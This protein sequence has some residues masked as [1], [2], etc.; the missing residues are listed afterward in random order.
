MELGCGVRPEN[1]KRRSAVDPLQ[2]EVLKYLIFVR[3]VKITYD[4]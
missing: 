4:L 2:N 3:F 1:M